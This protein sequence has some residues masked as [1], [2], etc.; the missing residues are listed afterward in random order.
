MEAWICMTH[1]V[2]FKKGHE[3]LREIKSKDNC[4]VVVNF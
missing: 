4:E 3:Y 2:L 1:F